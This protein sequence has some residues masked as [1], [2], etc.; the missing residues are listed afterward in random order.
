MVDCPAIL[1]NSSDVSSTLVAACLQAEAALKAAEIQASSTINS[2]WMTFASVVAALGAVAAAIAAY[3][4]AVR[5][6]Q[7]PE[8]LHRSTKALY[9]RIIQKNLYKLDEQ[10]SDGLILTPSIG[11]R[12]F[13]HIVIEIPY[14]L[15][16]QHWRRHALL[17][18]TVAMEMDDCYELTRSVM[19]MMESL[20]RQQSISKEDRDYYVKTYKEAR[21]TVGNAITSLEESHGLQPLGRDYEKRA[22]EVETQQVQ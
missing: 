4:A 6:V 20:D 14:H 8:Y 21:D 7:L 1:E 15:H 16:P 13:F 11:G 2:V 22:A 18:E 3:V 10:L 5:Q 17:G 12:L 19:S 9:A